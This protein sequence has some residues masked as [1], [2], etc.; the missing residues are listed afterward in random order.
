MLDILTKSNINLSSIDRIT[1]LLKKR[2]MDLETGSNQLRNILLN[3]FLDRMIEKREKAAKQIQSELEV[4]KTDK[5]RVADFLREQFGSSCSQR[6]VPDSELATPV[7]SVE[8]IG[9]PRADSA[10]SLPSVPS[11]VPSGEVH[12]HRRRLYRHLNSL[13]TT[14]FNFRTHPFS[15]SLLKGSK[16]HCY[17]SDEDTEHFPV[18]N[19]ADDLDDFSQV[20][21]GMSQYGDIKRLATLNYNLETS[22]A[23][24]IVS[25]QGSVVLETY[26]NA[27][28]QH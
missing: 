20:L 27:S 5:Q 3:E 21:Q 4:L 12:K 24:S 13:E 28:L 11:G 7:S 26:S 8:D 17:F 25:R 22:S 16:K 6:I 15:G 14:Y 2:R 19:C 10:A 23:L 18:G 1:D 9:S